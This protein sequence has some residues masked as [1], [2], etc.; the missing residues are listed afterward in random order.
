MVGMQRWP[1]WRMQGV[2]HGRNWVSAGSDH[3]AHCGHLRPLRSNPWLSLRKR[4]KWRIL[5]WGFPRTTNSKF[6]C[7]LRQRICTNTLLRKVRDFVWLQKKTP[8]PTEVGGSEVVTVE[9]KNKLS[10]QW[11]WKHHWNLN[12]LVQ[13][14]MVFFIYI[15]YLCDFSKSHFLF[16]SWTKK[17]KTMKIRRNKLKTTFSNPLV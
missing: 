3:N 15:A 7:W 17:Q 9:Q 14:T 1:A 8:R 13:E 10:K 5:F 11:N 2:H 4:W 16:I 6:I 12:P